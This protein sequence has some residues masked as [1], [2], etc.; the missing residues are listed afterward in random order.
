[1]E[2]LYE[3][4]DLLLINKPAGVVVN[5]AETTAETTVQEW[6]EERLKKESIELA[7]WKSLVPADFNTEY[8]TPEVIFKERGGIVHRLDKDTSGALLLAKNPGALVNVLAQFKKRQTHKTYTCLV[9]G[10][11]KFAK[12]TISAPLGRASLDRKKFAVVAE[13]RLAETEYQV[14]EFFP[15]L[16]VDAII[17]RHKK[18]KGDEAFKNFKKKARVY[19][20]FSLV[21]CWPKTGRT[22]QIRVHLKHIGHPLVGDLTYLGHKRAKLDPIWCSRQ[23]LHASS[24]GFTHPRNQDKLTIEAPLAED[25]KQVMSFLQLQ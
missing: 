6:M 7:D 9:H 12:G 24:L 10:K 25:L 15:H 19:Q 2:I 11:F 21:T 13:G 3:D 1:M 18:E 8:G 14:E 23:F 5:R 16:D 17:Q 20:G 4:H 22:H